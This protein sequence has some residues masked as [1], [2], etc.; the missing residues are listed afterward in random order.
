M[1]CVYRFRSN[2]SPDWECCTYH[3][4]DSS[5]GRDLTPRS[6]ILWCHLST[7]FS[8]S[9]CYGGSMLKVQLIC[10][11]SPLLIWLILIATWNT[12]WTLASV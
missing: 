1:A 10:R 4:N 7:S 9:L 11:N 8:N 3:R 6:H 2:A 5:N 12:A